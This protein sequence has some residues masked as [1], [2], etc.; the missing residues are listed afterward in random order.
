MAGTSS[1]HENRHFGVFEVDVQAREL[2]KKGSRVKLQQQPF[3][4]LMILLEHPG[5]VVSREELRQRLWPADVYVDFDRGLNKAMVKLRE[6]LGDSSGSPI[7]VETLPKVGYRFIGPVSSSFPL[8]TPAPTPSGVAHAAISVPA[9]LTTREIDSS[10]RDAQLRARPEAMPALPPPTSATVKF[11]KFGAVPRSL[12]VLLA[13]VAAAYGIYSLL[14]FRRSAPFESFTI[15]EITED[16][17]SVDAAIS[18]DGKYVL[19]VLDDQGEQSLWLRHVETKSNVQVIAP[20]PAAYDSLR[21]SPDGNFFYF[22]RAND[23][24]RSSYNLMRAPVLGGTPQLVVRDLD[25][26]ISFSPGGTRIVY[27]RANDPV[28]AKYQVLT[29]NADGT[30]ERLVSEG[31]FPTY[32]QIVAWSPDGKTLASLPPGPGGAISAVEFWDVSSSKV[33]AMVP[34]DRTPLNDLAWL[35]GGRGFLVLYQKFAEPFAPVQIGFLS[36]SAKQFRPVTNDTNTYRTLTLSTDGKTLATVQQRT[37]RTLYLLPSTGFAGSTPNPARVQRKDG[38]SFGWAANGEL[39]FNTGSELLQV[40]PEETNKKTLVSDP[41]AAILATSRCPD[42]RILID[43]A[44]RE[45]TNKINIWR[46]DADGSNPKQLSHGELDVAA[47]CGPESKWAYYNDLARLK[48]MRVP[49]DG[50]APE[51]VP[52]AVIPKEIFAGQEMA[53]S[54]DGRQLAFL[55]GGPEQ[56]NPFQKIAVV[57]LDAGPKPA[58]QLIDPDPRI[59]GS[60]AFTPDGKAIVYPVREK[61]VDNLWLQP[62]HASHGRQITNFQTDQ[63]LNF[64]FSDAG[65]ILGVFQQHLESDVVLLHD[66]GLSPR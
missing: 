34:F 38:T 47:V 66:V 44:G 10:E 19:S 15:A 5:D 3:E 46:V 37:S 58:A 39:Y 23:V 6:A 1:L 41:A 25:T 40:S 36:N 59:S 57:T 61:G 16:G 50:G 14:S 52:E 30:D 60:A 43:W 45:G 27:V 65:S 63:I 11:R 21:F 62:L 49:T 20:S 9:E 7:Y 53:I 48:V 55:V 13:L 24:A 12:I 42:G 4:L 17:K 31:D 64:H 33:E 32:P 54:P 56:Q 28:A 26:G 22:R 2:R 35:P 8:A 18:P 29:A 51:L